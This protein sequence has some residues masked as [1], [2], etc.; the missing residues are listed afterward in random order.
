MLSNSFVRFIVISLYLCLPSVLSTVK[1]MPLSHDYA[2]ITSAGRHNPFRTRYTETPGELSQP[3]QETTQVEQSHLNE[4]ISLYFFTCEPV[5]ASIINGK[6]LKEASPYHGA[7]GRALVR[8]PTQSWHSEPCLKQGY[9]FRLYLAPP[10]EFR[11]NPRDLVVKN[12][13]PQGTSNRGHLEPDVFLTK[14]RWNGKNQLY[15]SLMTDKAAVP[16]A[17]TFV[18]YSK[19]NSP[20]AA[21]EDLQRNERTRIN[22]T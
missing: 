4:P 14:H 10:T 9:A 5:A 19:G 12:A 20:Q 13:E 8:Y 1:A 15:A 18:K 16:P 21:I 3:Q 22:L 6:S 11:F 17:L 2:G 7:G